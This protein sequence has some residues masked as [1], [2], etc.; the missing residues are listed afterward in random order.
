MTTRSAARS[1][2]PRHAPPTTA[3]VCLQARGGDGHRFADEFHLLAHDDTGQP[4]L[5]RPV[6]AYGLAAALLAELHVSGRITV[7]RGQVQVRDRHRP[8]DAVQGVL[9]DRIAAVKPESTRVWLAF[10]GES[11]HD[12]VAH[13]MCQTGLLT[14]HS[15]SRWRPWAKRGGYRPADR[16]DAA[17]P[18]TRL[19]QQLRD[20]APLG[21]SD[22]I[23]AGLV[24]HTHLD[25][26]LLA[27]AS[28]RAR[29]YLREVVEDVQPPVHELFA[30]LAA[31][32]T[33]SVSPLG[34]PVP[35]ALR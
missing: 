33:T 5:P 10:F 29:V 4:R 23:L 17:W 7:D 2:V 25:T 14:S 11:A 15:G 8:A 22:R 24:L 32:V 18:W 30:A 28:L 20:R 3:P 19:S 1:H 21:D 27:G 16:F 12:R 35:G 9:L 13:R 6:A 31:L 26:A 34:E